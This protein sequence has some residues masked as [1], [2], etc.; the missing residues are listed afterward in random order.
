MKCVLTMFVMFTMSCMVVAAQG[1]GQ[2]G[3]SARTVN[4]MIEAPDATWMLSEGVV[5]R[6][7]RSTEELQSSSR[8]TFK[9]K[10]IQT[11]R[12]KLDS[13]TF[14]TMFRYTSKNS[15]L[16]SGSITRLLIDEQHRLWAFDD[17]GDASMFD[18]EK[19][20]TI[21]HTRPG[22]PTFR[23]DF[24]QG[25]FD[26]II[27]N[28]VL[29]LATSSYIDEIDLRSLKRTTLLESS[30]ILE[31]PLFL[32]F[33]VLVDDKSRNV[34]YL[35]NTAQRAYKLELREP[36]I[37]S[38]QARTIPLS[39]PGT[40]VQRFFEQRLTT[41]DL[42]L[43]NAIERSVERYLDSLEN[44]RIQVFLRSLGACCCDRGR[45]C[46][47]WGAL[48]PYPFGEYFDMVSDVNGTVFIA[49]REGIIVIPASS[50]EEE[51]RQASTLAALHIHPN[52][53]TNHV[54]LDLPVVP[55]EDVMVRLIDA[56]GS[57][58]RTAMIRTPS[59]TL[60][61]STLPNGMYT[62]VVSTKKTRVGRPLVIQR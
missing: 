47:G 17:D 46:I 40:P 14:P 12:M 35:D 61:V 15:P 56:S 9:N 6:K 1:Q 25:M 60:D 4:T 24:D 37:V 52:P 10:V 32:A 39:A 19:W 59:T 57:T 50:D 30:N 7:S 31:G 20:E 23:Y 51:E 18:G 44:G 5:L 29:R 36:H 41:I 54:L 55:T 3:Q 16:L 58:V 13:A 28:G 45:C 8:L 43:H 22:S 53:A 2:L 11:T 38:D 49:S 62:V 34:V 21:P 27:Q 48:S 42:D 33:D 26:V